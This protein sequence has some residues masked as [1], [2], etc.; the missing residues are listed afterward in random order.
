[1]TLVQYEDGEGGALVS[2]AIDVIRRDNPPRVTLIDFKSGDP[3]SDKHQT[4]DEDE[5][6][7][8][9]G[10]YGV[11]A[12][13]ELEYQPE[14]GLVRYL[15]VDHTK[16]ENHELNVPLDEKSVSNAKKTV[17][18]TATAIRD[19]RFKAGPRKTDDEGN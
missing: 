5:M 9:V 14:R 7:L 13:K 12:K 6:R 17:I 15:D 8:Q 3:E 19:R 16:N 4:L 18:E 10:I 2:G 11:A 1:E